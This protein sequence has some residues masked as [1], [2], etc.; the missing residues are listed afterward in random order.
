[1]AKYTEPPR[2]L[3]N[4]D[5][6]V[7]YRVVTQRDLVIRSWGEEWAEND[8]DIYEWANGRDFDSTD[9]GITGIYGKTPV[10]LD[11][12][13]LQNHYPD[14]PAHL[15]QQGVDNEGRATKWKIRFQ[16]S[17]RVLDSLLDETGAP[18]VLGESVLG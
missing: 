6:K 9:K 4:I 7:T 3:P 1:V 10:V 12:V 15:V 17:P 5:Y 11:A 18:F 13:I 2:S 14:A 16:Q 8:H